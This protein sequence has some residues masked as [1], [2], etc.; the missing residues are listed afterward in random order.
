MDVLCEKC[1]LKSYSPVE[2]SPGCFPCPET[3]TTNSSELADSIQS[4]ICEAGFG[5]LGEKC[6]E[7]SADTFVSTPSTV[8]TDKSCSDCP[9]HSTTNQQSKVDSV[10]LCL[11]KPGYAFFKTDGNNFHECKRCLQHTYKTS[12]S[13]IDQCKDCPLHAV[14][15]ASTPPFISVEDCKCKIGTLALTLA[16][17]LTFALI[18]ASPDRLRGA[19]SRTTLLEVRKEPI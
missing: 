6:I 17:T 8:M 1:P 16:L 4:C 14:T 19:R 9:E 13:N 10:A 2:N 5:I 3:S 18:L 12:L 11:C 7:C 15:D